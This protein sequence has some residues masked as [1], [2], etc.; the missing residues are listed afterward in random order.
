M[1]PLIA[2]GVIALFV[3]AMVAGR[4]AM[5]R[6]SEWRLEEW[7]RSHQLTIEKRESIGSTATNGRA[8]WR[9]RVVTREGDRR[10]AIVRGGWSVRE[11]VEVT[12][13]S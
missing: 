2:I 13:E 9:V 5:L 4:G 8:S 7:A 3:I 10:D 11:P 1:G 6:E 12:W